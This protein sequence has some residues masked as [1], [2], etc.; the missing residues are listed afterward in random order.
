M[1]KFILWILS[2]ISNVSDV[3]LKGWGRRLT[4]YA[5]KEPKLPDFGSLPGE[6]G[7]QRGRGAAG[8]L[9]APTRRVSPGLLTPIPPSPKERG[10]GNNPAHSTPGHNQLEQGGAVLR[11]DAC[12]TVAFSC[13]GYAVA[14]SR[15]GQ[16]LQAPPPP[17][18]PFRS[19][20]DETFCAS[21]TPQ[22]MARKGKS[23]PDS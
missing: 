7:G 6:L 13:W 3:S 10:R 5:Q 16:G 11:S 21:P 23:C 12:M 2:F 9:P 17:P 8:R 4:K 22:R 1:L 19:L 15:L 14:A 18:G 20:T